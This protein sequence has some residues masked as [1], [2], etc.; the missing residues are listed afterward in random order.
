MNT[1]AAYIAECIGTF[2]LILAGAGSII[3]LQSTGFGA[4]NLIAIALAHGL[5]IACMVSALGAISGGH[6]N[7]AVTFGFLVTKKIKASRAL[8]YII[9]QLAGATFAAFLLQH[10]FFQD[11]W[12]AANLGTPM[13]ASNISALQG[14]MI[15]AI[16]TFFLMLVIFGTTVDKRAPQ[17]GGL[18]IGL[19]ITVDILF[20]GPLTGAAMNPARTFGPAL[21]GF[22]GGASYNPWVGHLVY[23]IGPLIG[24]SMAAWLYNKLFSQ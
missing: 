5:T 1:S 18:F 6:F 13:L 21:A 7:P 19:V 3:A 22:I 14:I 8:K 16:M 4:A 10:I 12:Q 2:A 17:M 11:I 20:G 15:E 24:A 9:A 23:W